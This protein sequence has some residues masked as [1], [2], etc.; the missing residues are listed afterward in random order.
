M[1]EYEEIPNTKIDTH[2]DELKAES[3]ISINSTF[4]TINSN[5]SPSYY[6]EASADINKW[7]LLK[8]TGFH[9][10]DSEFTKY[11]SPMTLEGDTLVQLQ[12]WWDAI[13]FDF[14]K[15]LSTNKICPTYKKI[16]PENDYITKFP[17]PL[18]THYKYVTAKENLKHSQYQS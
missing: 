14:C 10:H 6:N 7:P 12:K 15:Y 1:K 13:S 11:I 2:I 8:S 4:S 3:Y 9:S 18:D 16:K 5:N 17:L